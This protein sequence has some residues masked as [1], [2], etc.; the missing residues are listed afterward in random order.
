MKRIL[1]ILL[2]L[3]CLMTVQVTWSQHLTYTEFMQLANK[4]SW[5]VI[6]DY[7]SAKGY[8][9]AGSRKATSTNEV[10][11]IAW[12]KNCTYFNF[13]Y[14]GYSWN[15]KKGIPYSILIIENLAEYYREY[16]YYTSS[17]TT[18]D[19]FKLSAKRNGFNLLNERIDN[20]CITSIYSKVTKYENNTTTAYLHFKT[21]KD[22]NYAICH[23]P[24]YYIVRLNAHITDAAPKKDETKPEQKK[25]NDKATDNKTADNSRTAPNPDAGKFGNGSKGGTQGSKDGNS[26][27][28]AKTGV[29]SIGSGLVGYGPKNFPK[30]HGPESGTVIVR[31]RVKADGKVHSAEIAGG[32]IKNA[33]QRQECLNKALASQFSVPTNKIT[34]GVG[35]IVYRFP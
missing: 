31:V 30:P 13:T 8:N 3:N 19:T 18:F 29:G 4:G 24:P 11:K 15:S 26:N 1:Q 32:T 9:Y 2:I 16:I 22:G 27:T 35:T 28:G 10:E 23:F 7:M 20:D 6:N 21:K 34:E 33:S 5:T 17:K 12:T 14:G 25:K